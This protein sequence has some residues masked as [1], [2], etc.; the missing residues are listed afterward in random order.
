MTIVSIL[1]S[2]LCWVAFM[3]MVGSP[4]KVYILFGFSGIYFKSMKYKTEVMTMNSEINYN[5][6]DIEKTIVPPT[7]I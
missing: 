5:D 3:G 7:S 6:S 4:R 1:T 2:P